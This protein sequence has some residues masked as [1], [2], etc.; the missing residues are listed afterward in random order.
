MFCPLHVQLYECKFYTILIVF[1]FLYA[2]IIKYNMFQPICSNNKMYLFEYICIRNKLRYSLFVIIDLFNH[3][4]AVYNIHK[5]IQIHLMYHI[6]TYI[7]D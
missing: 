6:R 3:L 4:A 5:K 7:N 2:S 1:L